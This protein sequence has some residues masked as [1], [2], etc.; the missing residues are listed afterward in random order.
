MDTFLSDLRRA[1]QLLRTSPGLVLVSVLSLGLG[2][3]VNLTLFTAIRAVFFREPTIA[4]R[5]RVVG[6]QPGNSNQFSYLNYRDLRDSGIFETVAGYRQVRLNLRSGDEAERVDGLAVTPNFFEAVRIPL[7]L[8]RAFGAV[9]AAPEREPR[10]AVISNAFWRRHFNASPAIVGREMTLNGESFTVIGVL[11][12]RY[13]PVTLLSDPA[14]YVPVTRLVL[15]TIGDRH[16]GNALGVLGW[17][18]PGTTREQAQAAITNLGAALEQYYPIENRGMSRPGRIVSLVGREFGDSP[19]RLVAP[20]ILLT[21]FGLVLLSACANV[22][23]LLLARSAHRQR[24]IA[25]RTA[26]GARRF[27]LV[28]M[29][30]AESFALALVGAVAGTLL[31]LWLMHT[32]DV[33]VLPGAGALNLALEADLS[34]AAYA[35]LLLIVTGLLC[36]IVPSWRATKTNVVAAI[37]TGE[38]RG[39]TGRLWL[40]HAFVVGQVAACVILL[41]LSS[42][43]LRSLFRITSMDPG[44]DLDRGLVASVHLDADRYATD[45]G[46]LL[47]ERIVERLEPLPGIE[48]AS[49]ANIVALG[50]DASITR[51]QTETQT[52][53]STNPRTFI[54]SVSPRYFATLGIPIVRGRDFEAR[55]REGSPPAVIVSEAFAKAYFPGNEPLGKRVRQSNDEP[56]A[57]IVGIVRDHKY[58][59]YDEAAT[60]ILYSAYAQRPRVSTQVRPVVV[61]LRTTGAP[62]SLLQNV[63]QVIAQIDATSSADVQTLRDAVGTEPALRRLGGQLL[64][65]AGA[66]G[67][68]LATIGLYGMMAFVV[69]SRAPEI[70]V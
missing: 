65:T 37:Q 36:G 4:D 45:G 33:I 67:L 49:F 47:G 64:A 24:E 7:A 55:D 2:L 41:V 69:A 51:F 20:T 1:L 19:V 44:F 58:Q 46:L 31:S 17:L 59:S 70:G 68:L 48:S 28:R 29:L 53:A 62:A 57:E 6:A 66:L 27:Q 14:V 21:L 16:N 38:S 35:L 50:T 25:I 61:H 39:S 5:D 32:L 8:G 63:K 11:P 26:L 15:P 34:L 10:V 60:P 23:G 18:R 42:L 22:A 52:D 40:R 43:M 12:A 54:N 3:G 30:L 56:Y 13:H 9:E